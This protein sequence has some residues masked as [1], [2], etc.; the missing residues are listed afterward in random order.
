M[1]VREWLSFLTR[2]FPCA[3]FCVSQT[4]ENL[5]LYSQGIEKIFPLEIPPENP[6]A[7]ST[8]L[9]SG[10]L[11]VQVER[12]EA[13]VAGQGFWKQMLTWSLA[14]EVLEIYTWEREGR[15]VG[16]RHSKK[17]NRQAGQ[18]SLWSEY[19]VTPG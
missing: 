15:G 5:A 19:Q 16:G 7:S 6:T 9:P 3:L 2:A 10:L 18:S 1:S 14:S 8:L 17:W 12:A 13:P 11:R 4:D